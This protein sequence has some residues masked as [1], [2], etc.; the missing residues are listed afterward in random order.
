[1][2][3]GSQFKGA[4]FVEGPM[5]VVDIWQLLHSNAREWEHVPK[6]SNFFKIRDMLD[7]ADRQVLQKLTDFDAA[8]WE[9]L[10]YGAGWTIIGAAALSWCKDA[11]LD[12]VSRLWKAI[13]PVIK[14]E[15]LTLRTAA[16][17]CPKLK[18]PSHQL[19]DIAVQL[20]GDGFKIAMMLAAQHGSVKIDVSY[21]ELAAAQET[22]RPMLG[23]I[24]REHDDS[25]TYAD[26]L[27][28]WSSDE[29]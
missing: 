4:H 16:M 21:A 29:E 23:H 6:N 19:S 26:L 1:M 2:P 24:L 7:E 18:P 27:E 20:E 14:P 22:L 8:R 9:Y 15:P 13:D 25:H 11:D 17:I 3:L 12:H 10:C 28:R 5:T